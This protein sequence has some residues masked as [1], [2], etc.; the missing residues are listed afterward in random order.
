MKPFKTHKELIVLLKS[1][2]LI[3]HNDRFSERI[4]TYENYY[5]VI[6]GYKPLFL[7]TTEPDDVY[8]TNTTFKEI[9]A[10]YTFDRR[11]RELLL[12]ELLRIE[13]TLKSKIAYTFSEKHGHKHTNYLMPDSFNSQTFENFR[14]TNALIHELIKLIDKQKYKSN[15]VTHYQKKYGFVPLWVLTKVM[16]FGKISMF[17]SCMLNSEKEEIAKSYNLSAAKFKSLLLILTDFRNKCAH[18]DRIY[19]HSRDTSKPKP[20]PI[21]PEHEQLHIPKNG[22]GYKYGTKDILALL[23]SLKY[24]MQPD[25]Y[26]RLLDRIY[27]ALHNKL[28]KRLNSISIADVEAVMGL[29]VNWIELKHSYIPKTFLETPEANDNYY[30]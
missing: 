19:C 22:K 6:N 30:D 9:F 7:S 16:T 15:A 5:S 23:I 26:D 10:L 12:P 2:G 18:D 4:L 27:Y 20:I 1:R 3:V 28:S 21:L 17:Y 11:L 29:T 25:R 8:K 14:R 24:F 13:H